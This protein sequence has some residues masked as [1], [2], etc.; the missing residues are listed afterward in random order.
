MDHRGSLF[1]DDLRDFEADSTTK[2]H[3]RYE[4]RL[5]RFGPAKKLISVLLFSGRMKCRLVKKGEM[6]HVEFFL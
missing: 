6:R 4:R 1:H 2:R 3:L 5:R